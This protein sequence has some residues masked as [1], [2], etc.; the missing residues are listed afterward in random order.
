MHKIKIKEIMAAAIM[1]NQMSNLASQHNREL[2]FFSHN[3]RWRMLLMMRI[4]TC[5]VRYRWKWQWCQLPSGHQNWK[6]ISRNLPSSTSQR[7]C[8]RLP[9][10]KSEKNNYR[11]SLR[12]MPP[13][14]WKQHRKRNVKSQKSNPAC[15]VAGSVKSFAAR[16][17]KR[18]WKGLM[19][20]Q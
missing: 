18:P 13:I 7:S 3:N 12:E 2:Q 19:F 1:A 16:R 5:G 4:N 15:S 8:S 11:K 10:G 6:L 14:W 9:F 20:V 17:D